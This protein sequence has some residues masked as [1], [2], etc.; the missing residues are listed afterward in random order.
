MK[1][2]DYYPGVKKWK[3][4]PEDLAGM[5]GL[6]HV[7]NIFYVDPANGNDTSNSGTSQNDA[8]ATIF[9]AEA[10]LTDYNH[11]VVIL[12]PGANGA[13][14]ESVAITWDKNYAHLIGNAAPTWYGPRARMDFITDST[15]PCMTIS[16][17][18]CR[19]LNVKIETTQANN[20]VLVNMTGD[21]NYFNNV[22]FQGQANS[23]SGDDA[24]SRSLVLTGSHENRFDNC[25]IGNDTVQMSTT[26]TR[27]ELAGASKNFFDGCTFI[28]NADNTGATH[29]K[30]TGV[31]GC[32]G[33]NRF[34]DCLFMTKWTNLGNQIL[35]N[36]DL[37]AQT[38][39]AWIAMTG[40][41]MSI[42]ADDWE[43]AASNILYFDAQ[44]GY[45]NAAFIG[46]A[47]NQT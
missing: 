6:P 2:H 7:G 36:F 33:F 38:S 37:S 29:V 5:L 30:S 24:T 3:W 41:N 43:A 1:A 10:K 21:R 20:D 12:V 19:F 23:E 40:N 16:G 22:H 47:L 15:D 31:G 44:V 28:M 13:S 14:Q 27:L 35:G 25:T 46:L 18:G 39:S 8:L 17:S 9:A 45:G 11:D 4:Y 42:G 26:N 32:E 34:N